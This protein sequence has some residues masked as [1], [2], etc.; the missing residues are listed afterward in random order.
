MRKAFIALGVII[1]ALLV[2]FATFNQQPKYAGVSM[3]KTD[4]RHLEQSRKSIKSFIKSLDNFDYKK[5]STMTAIEKSGN[6]I[7]KQNS[8]NLS[9]SDAQALR[10]AF[11]GKDGIITIVQVAKKGN[12]NIDSSVASRFHDKFDTIIIMVVNAMNKSSAQ[13]AEIVDQMKVDLNIEAAI[14]KIGEKNEE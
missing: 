12:Y 3:P 9:N 5:P 7:I 10:N 13:R 14:Y 1:I 2:A 8:N 4:Y 11:Y 6:Q